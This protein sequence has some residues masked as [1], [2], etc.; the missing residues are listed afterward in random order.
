MPYRTQDNRIDGVVIT[1]VEITVAKTMEGTL[2]EA[3][4]VLQSRFTDQ[5]AELDAARTL[6]KVLQKAQAVL[7]KHLADQT[8]E[9]R[10]SRADFHKE[11]EKKA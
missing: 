9:L 6:E 4:S 5:T 7:E 1:F 11:K 2:R 3:L 10:Q 8:A